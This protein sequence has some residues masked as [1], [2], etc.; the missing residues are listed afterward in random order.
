MN[1]RLALGKTKSV[2]LISAA[3]LLLGLVFIAGWIVH[4]IF[5]APIQGP[6][7]AGTTLK[8]PKPGPI[9]VSRKVP[10]MPTEQPASKSKAVPVSTPKPESMSAS[11]PDSATA[12]K[13]DS[14]P[15]PKPAN[16]TTPAPIPAPASIEKEKAAPAPTIASDVEAATAKAV[17]VPVQG[18]T[19]QVGAFLQAKNANQF[20]RQLKN[21]GY[22]AYIYRFADKKMRQWHLVRIGDYVTVSEAAKARNDFKTKEKQPAVITHIDSLQQVRKKGIAS[23]TG[24]K[25]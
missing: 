4:A 22:D 18:Y 21:R 10:F 20:N 3:V 5:K 6:Q 1:D 23:S 7:K 12:A 8:S 14:K 25:P 2:L 11:K 24:K 17:S 9:I 13:T 19:V 16:E 15:A